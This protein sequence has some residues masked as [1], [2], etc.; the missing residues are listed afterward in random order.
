MSKTLL[1]RFTCYLLK[2]IEKRIILRHC[3]A[4]YLKIKG[5]VF[6]FIFVLYKK[7]EGENTFLILSL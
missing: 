1:K 7:G 6:F 5:I 2:L 3:K 4:K